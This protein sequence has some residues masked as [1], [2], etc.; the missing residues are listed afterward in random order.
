LLLGLFLVVPPADFPEVSLLPSREDWGFA[1]AKR[2]ML[3]Q[4]MCTNRIVPE[5]HSSPGKSTWENMRRG[6]TQR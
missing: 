6:I 5:P 4:S 2:H 1:L 3:R